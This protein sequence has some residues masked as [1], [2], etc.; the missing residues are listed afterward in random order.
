MKIKLL[1]V[2]SL[3]LYGQ[4]FAQADKFYATTDA[5]N[6]KELEAKMPDEIE[7]LGSKNNQSVIFISKKGAE[8]LHHNV[9]THGPGYVYK[10]SKEEALSAIYKAKKTNK[11]LAFT[12]DQNAAVTATIAKVNADNI[13]SH[14]Q[15][16]ENYGTRHHLTAKAQSA[17]AI[18]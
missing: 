9:V 15:V 14:I 10:S 6:A 17:V 5:D 7:I 2:F 4:A 13:K 18:L 16:L 8:F 3:F 12:I 11:V 1:T